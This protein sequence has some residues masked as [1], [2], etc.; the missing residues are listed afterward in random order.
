[1]WK[2]LKYKA[3]QP[4]NWLALGLLGQLTGIGELA[5]LADQNVVTAIGIVMGAILNEGPRKPDQ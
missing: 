3:M 2:K 4:T 5:A 1:M